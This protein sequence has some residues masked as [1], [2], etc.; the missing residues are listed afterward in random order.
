MAEL[1]AISGLLEQSA[2]L[3][4][5]GWVQGSWFSVDSPRGGQ[6]VTTY[7]VRLTDDDT[8]VGACLVGSV[9]QAAGGPTAVRSQLVQR[10]LDL[11]WHALCGDP[12][13]PVRWCPDLPC[14]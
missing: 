14:G 2:E 10:T 1:H 11:V 5:H 7:G 4:S 8:V 12:G 13:R 3:V 6:A 9:V